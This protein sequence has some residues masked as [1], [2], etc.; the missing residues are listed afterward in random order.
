MLQKT[1]TVA[2]LALVSTGNAFTN[3]IVSILRLFLRQTSTYGK[4][5][6]DFRENQFIVLQL[7]ASILLAKQFAV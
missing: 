1:A 7:K 3:R 5:V 2:I 4:C 6:I